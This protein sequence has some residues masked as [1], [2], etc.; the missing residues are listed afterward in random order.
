MKLAQYIED[1]FALNG[2]EVATGPQGGRC[3]LYYC[4][5]QCRRRVLLLDAE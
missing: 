2:I 4:L 5:P 1:V 3:T